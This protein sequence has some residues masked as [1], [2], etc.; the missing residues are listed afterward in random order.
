MSEKLGFIDKYKHTGTALVA[1]LAALAITA[2]G[3]ERPGTTPSPTSERSVSA[4]ATP[5]AERSIDGPSA[6]KALT[7]QSSQ[8]TTEFVQ[9]L[10]SEGIIKAVPDESDGQLP[11][12]KYNFENFSEKELK[13]AFLKDGES[14]LVLRASLDDTIKKLEITAQF[15]TSQDHP[16]KRF[17]ASF[18]LL[19]DNPGLASEMVSSQTL[20]E[21]VSN[22]ATLQ[23]DR[24]ASY[25][26]DRSIKTVVIEFKDGTPIA[27]NDRKEKLPA[28]DPLVQE[29]LQEATD[30]AA[31][32]K[33]QKSL[34]NQ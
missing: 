26:K 16:Q 21:A 30:P 19:P 18:T 15:E 28:T 3:S 34:L 17:D 25:D 8:F 10:E 33:F 4:S 29:I 11:Y 32:A 1:T 20:A 6:T 23:L 12:H 5:S 31:F 24:Y 7:E 2:C 27:L 14:R 13:T 22:P 9:K